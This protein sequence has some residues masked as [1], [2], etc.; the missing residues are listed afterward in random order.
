LR[1]E[2]E[3]VHRRW[4]DPCL[5]LR[6]NLLFLLCYILSH[7]IAFDVKIVVFSV[8]CFNIDVLHVI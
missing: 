8:M 1:C 6:Y 2:L 3:T 7:M 5:S 4:T